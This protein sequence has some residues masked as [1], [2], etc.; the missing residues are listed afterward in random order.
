MTK[1]NREYNYIVVYIA[2]VN[3]RAREVSLCGVEKGCVAVNR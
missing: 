1:K 3:I 2:K